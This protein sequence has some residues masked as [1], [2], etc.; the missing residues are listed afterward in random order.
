MP[1]TFGKV[2]RR[3]RRRVKPIVVRGDDAIHR[4]VG[5]TVGPFDSSFPVLQ[6]IHPDNVE[7]LADAEFTASCREVSGL[8]L[9]DTPRLAN[10]W[11]LCRLCDPTGS[12]IE[13][14]SF[15]G[16]GALHLSNSAP[17]RRM[18]VCDSFAGFERLDDELDELFDQGMFVDTS[19]AA[20]ER[21]FADRGRDVLILAG[22]FPASADGHELGPLSFAHLDVDVYEATRDTLEFIRPLMCARS[23]IVLDDVRRG[24]KGVDVAISEFVDANPDWLSLP[25][26]PG[27]GLLINRSWFDG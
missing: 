2:A 15:R 18:I 25:L 5:L 23:M 8:T 10:L 22:F 16:G 4:R 24:A 14:G 11:S 9:L 19:A 26:F 1:R 13:V 7:I 27:Q 17:E 21:L 6:P 12:V 20:V 3:V